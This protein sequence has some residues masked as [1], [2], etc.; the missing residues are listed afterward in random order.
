MDKSPTND[1][2]TEDPVSKNKNMSNT[3][4]K[5]GSHVPEGTWGGA[6]IRAVVRAD[7]ADVEYDCAHGTINGPLYLDSEGRFEGAG[8]HAREGGPVRIDKPATGRP[9]RYKGKINGN[10]MT[11][12]VTFTENSESVGTFTLTHGNEGRLWKCR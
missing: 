11:L 5:K 1:R 12:I 6:H 7:G 9:V 10:E 8:T 3:P 4:S 2:S